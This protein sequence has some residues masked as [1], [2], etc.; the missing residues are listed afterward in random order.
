MSFFFAFHPLH[1]E[2]VAW[3][4]ERKDVLC[5]FFWMA[6]CLCYGRYASRPSIGKYVLTVSCFALGLLAK[7][8]LVTLPFVL[9]LLDYWPLNRMD[10]SRRTGLA[11]LL[12]WVVLEKLPFA[13]LATTSCVITIYAQGHAHAIRSLEDYPFAPRAS[14]AAVTYWAYLGQTFWPWNLGLFYPHASLSTRLGSAGLVSWQVCGAALA[15]ALVTIFVCVARKL[16]YLLVGW[17]WYLGTLVPVIGLVQV[18]AASRADRYTYIPL[19]GV[20]IAG[21]W[22]IGDLACRW[23]AQRVVVGVGVVLS[24]ACVTHTWGQV[25]YW[26]SDLTL[27]EHTLVAC[28]ESTVAH[29]HLGIALLKLDRPR[30]AEEEFR[31]TLELDPKDPWGLHLLGTALIGQSKMEEA[32]R[33]YREALRTYPQF[34]QAHHTLG[35]ALGDLGRR[36]EAIAEQEETLRLNPGFAAAHRS[37]GVLLSAE[38]RLDEAVVHLREAIAAGMVHPSVDYELARILVLQR[39]FSEA[40]EHIYSALSLHAEDWRLRALLGLALYESGN[41]AAAGEQYREATRLNPAWPEILNQRAWLLA[42]YPDSRGRN[43]RQAVQ[44]ALQ[45]C[46]AV[47]NRDARFLDTLAAAYAEAG[48]FEK[49]CQ[50][51][52][53]AC[54]IATNVAK[55]DLAREISARLKLYKEGRAFHRVALP[56]DR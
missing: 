47:A 31:K 10:R 43:G 39:K 25:Q 55:K 54:S 22:S 30:A 12:G 37:L 52:Q 24:L 51:A 56:A 18:G 41:Q 21:V 49:A 7:P 50:T 20:F 16:P 9:L 45:A 53:Q 42:T 38:G 6:T 4:A 13:L 33:Q 23:R 17:F 15:L 28:G 48:D 19:I 11:P 44:L 46:Q 27:W 34:D 26:G 29:T 35:L 40:I 2:S 3:I 1:V 5:A 32:V 14:N 36:E 8:M